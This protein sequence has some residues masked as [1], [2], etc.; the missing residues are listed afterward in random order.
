MAEQQQQQRPATF[1]AIFDRTPQVH[2]LYVSSSVREALIYEPE[3]FIGRSALE[4]A[5]DDKDTEEVVR[6]FKRYTDDNFIM[7]DSIAVSKNKKPVFLRSMAF[8]LGNITFHLISA[9]PQTTID[10]IKGRLSLQRFK[11]D[12]GERSSEGSQHVLH[13]AS[14]SHSES[15][16]KNTGSSARGDLFRNVL[17][18]L[19][20]THQACIVLEG[21][22]NSRHDNKGARIIFSTDSISRILSVDS[23]DLQDMPFLSLV[24]LQD[25]T[26]AA[27]FL[28]TTLH[29]DSLMFERLCLLE[30]PVEDGQLG[31][32]KCVAVEFM[33]MGSDDGVIMLCQLDH[34]ANIQSC[35]SNNRYLSL[36]DIVSSDAETSDFVL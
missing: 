13:M 28:D 4:F 12:L 7:A 21:F 36:E 29:G 31:N 26:R 19:K 6:D 25:I 14:S 8:A 35:N 27:A 5:S 15:A 24:A 30:N 16:S 11:C 32:P 18:S 2:V 17:S 20:R 1:I 9:Y 33:A 10:E 3:E 22:S 23:C 34:S